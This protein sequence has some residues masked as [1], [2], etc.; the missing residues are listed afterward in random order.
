[1]A[2]VC[3]PGTAAFAAAFL[4][5]SIALAL[6]SVARIAVDDV[7]AGAGAPW[8]GPRIRAWYR[9][10]LGPAETW[11]AERGWS[12]DALT[13]GQLGLSVLAGWAY[14]EAC[15]FLGGCLVLTAGT[16]DVLDGGLARRRGVA[17]PRGA[18]LDSVADRWAE[19][20]TFFGL[21]VLYRGGWMLA[22]VALA[23]FGSQMVSYVRARAEGLGI[24]MDSGRAQRPERYVLLGFGSVLAGI[25]GHLTCVATG[26]PGHGVLSGCLVV[27]AVVS[28]RTATDRTRRAAAA[29]RGDA[30]A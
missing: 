17:G 20:A 25:V 27:L 4:A 22:I 21:G 29:L 14:A 1:V 8:I 3:R 26:R 15:V 24:A 5:V 10:A 16:L 23:A 6:R 19:F 11:L 12:P 7:G 9:T 13:Y 2:P 28:A 18:L 30:A